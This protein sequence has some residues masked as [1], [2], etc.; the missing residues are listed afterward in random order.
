M[1][2]SPR[3]THRH[4]TSL[5]RR[6]LR[7]T[8]AWLTALTLMAALLAAVATYPAARASAGPALSGCNLA[9]NPIV[10]E[11]QNTGTAESLWGVS[12]AGDTSIQG[13]ATDQSVDIGQTINFKVSTAATSWHIDIVRVGWYGGAGGR[14]VASIPSLPAQN[15]PSC[16]VDTSNTTGLVDCGNWSVSASWTVPGSA[17]SGVYFAD[18]IR[19]DTGGN[20]LIQFEVRNDAGTAPILYQSADVTREAYNRY[21]GNSLY[22]CTVACPPGNPLVYKAAYMVSFNRPDTAASLGSMYSFFSAEYPMVEFL[23]QNGYDV[24]YISGVDTDRLGASYI[25]QHKLFMDSG[26]DEYWSGGQRA[27]VTAARDAGVNLAFFS[28]NEVFWK[29]RYQN[30][31]DGSNTTYRTLVTYKE[32]HFN[33][34]ADP[35]D[36]PTWTGDWRD[37]RYSPPADANPENALT[38]QMYMVDPPSNFAIQVPAAYA[39]LRLWKNTSVAGL[40][41]TQTATLAPN[42]LGY[43]FDE[44][45]DNGSR[46]AGEIDM[47]STTQSVQNLVQDYYTNVQ[48]PG[49]ATHHLTLY[50]AASGALVFATGTVQWAFGLEPTGNSTVNKDQQQATVNVFADLGVQPDFG[51]QAGATDPA[52]GLAAASASTDGTPPVSTITAPAAG[53]TVANGSTVTVSGTATDSGG[54][55]V[56]GVEI[57]TNGGASWHPASIAGAATSTTWSYTWAVNGTGPVTIETRATDDS[58]N[59][60]KPTDARTVNVTCPCQIFANSVTPTLIDSNDAHAAELGVKFTSSVAGYVTG[61]RFYKAGTN[62][63]THEGDLYSSSGQLLAAAT[64]SNESASGWQNVTFSPS[65]A[66]SANTTYVAAYHTN[67]GHESEDTGVFSGRYVSSPPLTALESSTDTSQTVNVDGPNG[68]YSYSAGPTF[69]TSTFKDANYYVD[70]TFVPGSGA[71]TVVSESPAPGS[72]GALPTATVT[73]T[74]NTAVV[75]SSVKFTLTN[76]SGAAVAASTS[77]NSTT[78]TATLTPTSAL[79]QGTTYTA[80]VSGATTSAG[81][82]MTVPVSWTFTTVTCPCTLWPPSATPAVAA[83]SDGSSVELG[84]QFTPL[85]NGYISGVRFYKGSTNTGTHVGSLWT[86][87][88]TLLAQ[89]TFA[90]ESASGWQEAAF[91]SPVAVQSGTTYVI[92]YHAPVGHYSVNS[93]YFTASGFTSGPLQASGSA[94][95]GLYLYGSGSV[96]PTQTYNASNYWVSPVFQTSTTSSTGAPTVTSLSP[97]DGATGV[98]ITTTVTATFDQAVTASSVSISLVSSGGSSVAGTTT[99]NASLQQATFTPTTSLIAGASYTATVSGATNSSGQTMASPATATFTTAA[100]AC[101]CTLWPSSANPAVA[102]STDT[103]AYELGTIFYAD[104]SGYITGVRFYKGA[105][106]TGTHVGNLWSASGQLLASGTFTNET[107][108]GWQQLTFSSPVAITANT[109]YVA[110]YHTNV[111]GYSYTYSYFANPYDNSPLHAPAGNNGVYAVGA[112]AFPTQTYKSTS[113]WVDAVFTTTAP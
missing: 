91:K 39:A 58:A 97:A 59:T 92:S 76:S 42:T 96:F 46:P 109:N 70:V 71:P 50:R 37:T 38:G 19:D 89:V 11:N 84:T 60:E 16:V 45:L 49:T 90:N 103:S 100:P 9:A 110:S 52:L 56:A 98:P 7:R 34:P 94:H 67:V 33:A 102:S 13:F 40:T 27:N 10:C 88:G 17:V 41:G 26:H 112:S 36:P 77:Y 31:I 62:T 2:K 107:A 101:P 73:A 30:S 35:Q 32:T 18:L 29:T 57:S 64:F 85:M 20:S 65:V 95:N 8:L 55:V 53:A 105:G 25:E 82:S 78:N 61:I 68:L 22:T 47:S 63:G 74:F 54:G 75:A 111:G 28:G 48:G 24:N 69:P 44:D 87:A 81:Q 5:P 14:I 66:I 51:G 80:T 83:A 15:Q 72:T 1:R 104:R 106:N 3:L 108:S 6:P 113:Y 4:S 86:T 21:G 93:A 43:E 23:E 99:Y 12:G 79:A